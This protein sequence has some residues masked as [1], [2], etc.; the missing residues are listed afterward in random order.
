VLDFIFVANAPDWSGVSRIL[1]QEGDQPATENDFDDDAETTDHRPVDVLLTLGAASPVTRGGSPAPAAVRRF[2]V[3]PSSAPRAR[4]ARDGRPARAA[5]EA[6][7]SSLTL[8]AWNIEHLG[9]DGDETSGDDLADYIITSGVAVLGL[10]EI[11]DTDGDDSTRTNSTLDEALQAINDKTGDTWD[12]RLFPKSEHE[13]ESEQN[14][15]LTGVAWNT[16]RVQLSGNPLLI[17]VEHGNAPP[18]DFWRRQ[19]FAVKFTT[20][21]DKTDF[22]VIPVHMR[23]NSRRSG[24]TSSPAS[25]RAS[26]VRSLLEHLDFV[27][28]T[29]HDDDIVVLGDSNVLRSDER[30]LARFADGGFRDL[31]SSGMNTWM[32]NGQRRSPFDR[33]F[34]PDDQPEFADAEQDVVLEFPRNLSAREFNDE[35]SDHLMILTTIQLMEDDD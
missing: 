27:R 13:A 17:P 1:D 21:N 30:A 26:E 6:V 18:N 3:A 24:Q 32:S 9:R 11:Y 8:G 7:G 22:V 25:L 19:P 2:G 12:Y 5:A 35:V 28:E 34:V 10:E 31:N 4:S 20:S 29:F 15:Q 23:S 33:F 14:K 16:A